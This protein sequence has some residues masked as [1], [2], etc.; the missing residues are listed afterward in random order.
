MLTADNY[1]ALILLQNSVKTGFIL[2]QTN[3][4]FALILLHFLL[5]PLKEVLKIILIAGN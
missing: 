3:C 5:W 1:T 2:L 4:K